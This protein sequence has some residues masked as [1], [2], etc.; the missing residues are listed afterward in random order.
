[1]K[2]DTRKL[3]TLLYISISRHVINRV[4]FIVISLLQN[5]CD[6]LLNN[7]NNKENLIRFVDCRLVGRYNF[8]YLYIKEV[9]R[10]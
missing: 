7:K 5:M 1:M 2:S 4:L 6:G 9:K 10:G 3:A 8:Y